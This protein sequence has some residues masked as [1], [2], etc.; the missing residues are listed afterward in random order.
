MAA[1]FGEGEA[2]AVSA[3]AVRPR[4]GYGDQFLRN[5][6]FQKSSDGNDWETVA[7]IRQIARPEETIWYRLDFDNREPY[8]FWR[9]LILDGH[10]FPR[11][12]FLS[13]ADLA[14]F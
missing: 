1:D 3:L 8:R 5:A 14:L 6:Q 12:H 4:N 9:L 13:M 7:W 11:G 2:V 10:T